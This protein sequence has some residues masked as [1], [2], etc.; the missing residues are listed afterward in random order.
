MESW[1]RSAHVRL[2]FGG[3]LTHLVPDGV[4]LD[5][6]PTRFAWE[7]SGRELAIEIPR[8]A[9]HVGVELPADA[10]QPRCHPAREAGHSGV[11]LRGSRIESPPDIQVEIPSAQGRVERDAASGLVSAAMG[12]ADHLSVVWGQAAALESKPLLAAVDELLWLKIRP[13]SVVLEAQFHVRVAEGRLRQI[14]LLADPRLRSLPLESGS[15]VAQIRTEIDDARTI[16]LGLAHPVTDQVAFRLSFLLTDTSGIGNLQVPKLDVV[17]ARTINRRLAISIESPL[18]LDDKQMRR[19]KSIPPGDFLAAWGTAEAKPLSAFQLSAGDATPNLAIHSREPQLASNDALA[20]SFGRGRLHAAWSSDLSVQGGSIYQVHLSAPHDFHVNSATLREAGGADRPLRSVARDAQPHHTV[21]S[22]S[23]RRP[24]STA[25]PRRYAGAADRVERCPICGPQA[26]RSNRRPSSSSASRE[27][28]SASPIGPDSSNSAARICSRP[29]ITPSV[30]DC[31]S[32]AALKSERL[33]RCLTGQ[34]AAGPMGLRVVANAPHVAGVEMTSMEGSA[35]SWAAT[36]DLDLTISGGVLDRLHLE[37][38]PQWSG[39][40]E[41]SP[42]MPSEIVAEP[43][44]NRRQLLLRPAEP[45]S[46]PQHIRLTAPVTAGAGQPIRVPDVR[47]LGL[48]SLRQFVRLPTNS[49]EQQLS[50]VTHGLNFERLPGAF[51]PNSA[52][53]EITRTCQVIGETFEATLKSVEKGTQ[54]P[55]VRLVDIRLTA[56]DDRT[57]FGAAAF[58]LEPGGATS[59]LLEMPAGYRLLHVEAN[60]APAVVK[61]IASNQWNIHGGAARLPRRIEIVFLVDRAIGD[62]DGREPWL[63]PALVGYSVNRTLWTIDGRLRVAPSEGIEQPRAIAPSEGRRIRLETA[64]AMLKSASGALADA[65]ERQIARIDTPCGAQ[66][67]TGRI[68]TDSRRRGTSLGAP[69]EIWQTSAEARG[70]PRLY[71]AAGAGASLRLAL[72]SDQAGDPAHRILLGLM[73]AALLGGLMWLAGRPRFRETVARWPHWLGVLAGF[74]WW[75]WLTPSIFGWGIVAGAV[76]L[77][78]QPAWPHA[79]RA[80]PL[81]LPPRGSG[82]FVATSTTTEN[83]DPNQG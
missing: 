31:S 66:L 43:G 5:G 49:D 76:I 19:L 53:T 73:L 40:P 44:E 2:P 33:V 48:G 74:A 47:P 36:V 81:P 10:A 56:I 62:G 60:D 37:L 17:G 20:V 46:G 18:E 21:S 59:C 78:F 35:D 70:N 13:G 80:K 25:A 77:A 11:A 14:Q 72:P 15:P 27:C 23:S 9:A 16:Y 67:G 65:T 22:R 4:R 51:S 39:T 69:N 28:W 42:P 30:R 24:L 34:P 50:W 57:G 52:S 26:A 83:F 6:A 61:Q 64:T 12:P 3:A 55:R 32:C 63:A 41:I 68:V 54:R 82:A 79:E 38:P 29:S 58:D 75:L 8:G 71:T 7:N 1:D 45:L